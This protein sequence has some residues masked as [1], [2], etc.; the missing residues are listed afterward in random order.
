L[1]KGTWE[2]PQLTLA[3]SAQELEAGKI[4][5]V[6]LDSTLKL[7]GLQALLDAQVELFGHKSLALTGRVPLDLAALL[8]APAEWKKLL[9]QAGTLTV[10]SNQLTFDELARAGLAPPDAKGPLEA[11]LVLSG[12]LAKPRLLVEASG[13][14]LAVSGLHDLGVGLKVALDH[15]LTVAS[16]MTLGEAKAKLDATL[17]LSATECV[18]LAQKGFAREQL[19]P[20]LERAWSGTLTLDDFIIGKMAAMTTNA[21]APGSGPLAAPL[22]QGAL[23]GK[24]TLA[25][26]PEAPKLEGKFALDQLVAGQAKM[27]RGDLYVSADSQGA[28]L[29]VGLNPPNHG[30]VLLAHAD[31]QADLSATSL[32]DDGADAVL[33]G[34]LTG[35]VQAQR[36]DLSV[37]SNAT[38]TLR[39]AAGMLDADIELDGLLGRPWATG[40]A[41]LKSAAF[42]LAGVGALDDVGLDATF[43]PKEIVCDRL[44]GSLGGGQFSAVLVLGRRTATGDDDDRLEFT[45]EL[46]F[47]DEEA[48]RDRLDAQGKPQVPTPV[49]IRVDG[50]DL[51]NIV[52]EME[53][54][55]DYEQGQV[56]ATVQMPKTLV[57]VLSLPDKKL[58]KLKPNPDVLV[59]WPNDQP[60]LAGVD[61][62]EMR[63][64][65]AARKNANLRVDVALDLQNLRVSAPDFDLPVS[66]QMHVAWDAS[67]P[68]KPIADGSIEVSGGTFSA[69]GRR[70]EIDEAKITETGGDIA[71][72]ELEI[73]AR[74]EN[75]QASVLVLISGTAT[76]PQID[77]SSTPAM[78]QDAIAFFLAT[79]RIQGHATQQGGGVDLTN[80]ATSVLGAALFGQ[81]RK[82]LNDVLPID[83]VTVEG[84]QGN[85]G[86]QASLGKYI[87]D[88]LFIGYR[89]RFAASVSENQIEVRAEFL[90][91]RQ[92]ASEGTYG[93]KTKGVSVLYTIEW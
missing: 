16:S 33:D 90:L 14:G 62:K 51:A 32:L 93:D 52:T 11:E 41:H 7:G 10:A 76:A 79:G 35:H 15:E 92:L 23:G 74:Y 61:P 49:P 28:V 71:D 83:V 17:A 60:A 37:L 65:L 47:G 73:Q 25:G 88:R 31:L 56:A 48:A 8:K 39:R 43:S 87:G 19:D 2:K 44:S 40:E 20:L 18:A 80:A 36:F 1:A 13:Q 58:P 78:D 67:N 75:P 82:N 45:G 64:I 22:F 5:G 68:D 85:S 6:A 86:P 29:H 21:K 91:G 46:H 54:Y 4:H 69:L 27:G 38:P 66:S 50:A 34:T 89:Q 42:D 81:L 9:A 55:G 77:L 70:F 53:F 72:P 24:L 59:A 30:G 63:R 57:R 84:G 3:V 26:T 12:T